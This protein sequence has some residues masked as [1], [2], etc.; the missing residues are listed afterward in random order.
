VNV[1]TSEPAIANVYFTDEH[2]E[3]VD[4]DA[5]GDL[6]IEWNR[7]APVDTVWS[8]ATGVF[9]APYDHWRS[10]DHHERGLLLARVPG[11]RPGRRREPMSVIDIAPTLAASLGVAAPACDGVAH[12]DLLPAA[13]AATAV[14]PP[15]APVAPT[16]RP[17]RPTARRRWSAAALEVGGRDWVED[18]TVGLSRALHAEH[19]KIDALRADVNRLDRLARIAPVSAWIRDIDVPETIRVSVVMATRN[20]VG[21][22]ERAIESVQQQSYSNWELLI[23]DDAST[24]DTFTRLEK[25]A[26]SDPRIRPFRLE[27]QGRASGARNHALER[28]EGDVVVYLDD[29]NRFDRDWC[30]AVA[31][32]FGEF[33]DVRVAYGA[34]VIDD[35]VR[36]EGLDGRSLPFVQ[37]N[38]WDREAMLHANL[39]DVNVVAHR[40][41]DVRFDPVTNHFADW[42]LLL[43]LTDDC[44]PLAL[45]VVA[46][47]YTSDAPGRMSLDLRDPQFE[48]TGMEYVRASTRERRSRS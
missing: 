24:D 16:P 7:N 36:H 48:R 33:D 25:F 12:V 9:S 8:P 28:A 26:A 5:M 35:E 13:L 31:W 18:Y 15:V 27:R 41:S 44:D 34:R 22:I 42:H 11:V 40:R 29:D 6:I 30:K 10:G 20:R 37:F 2:Y 23:V 45:P 32:A 46:S 38:A 19:Q 43:E 4:G 1:E 17:A 47:Y 39:V 14:A 21:T 3:R